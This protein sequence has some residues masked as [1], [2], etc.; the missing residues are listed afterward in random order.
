MAMYDPEPVAPEP[1]PVVRPRSPQPQRRSV[2]SSLVL[3]L[4]AVV[5]VGG[6]A[7]A[8]GRLTA[9]TAAAATGFNGNGARANG[10]FGNGEFPRASG[11]LGGIGGLR[12]AGG[13]GIQGTVTAVASDHLTLQLANGTTIDIPLGSSTTYHQQTAG[14]ASDVQVGKQVQVQ[15]QRN[16]GTGG[17]AP[18]AG[19]GGG[20]PTLGTASSVT[21]LGQ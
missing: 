3:G 6:L 14:T 9:P 13:F 4:A 17:A 7:F 19:A 11:A 1:A 5:A 20:T 16:S 12:G 8:A 15:L 2:A 21:V 10:G 18:S